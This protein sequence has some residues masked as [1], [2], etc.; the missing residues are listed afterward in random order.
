MKRLT[1]DG[2]RICK[3]VVVIFNNDGEAAFDQMVPSVG[4]IALR[5]LGAACNAVQ[6]LLTT[7]EKSS[8]RFE[9]HWEYR[10]NLILTYKTGFL[11]NYR[12][13]V[14]LQLC[15]WRSHVFFLVRCRNGQGG[16]RFAIQERISKFLE[17][18]RPST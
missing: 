6:T 12:V 1:Y 18:Q 2:M 7:F 11:E 5:R 3:L 9:I 10:R 13:R 17:W 8:T 15:G 14:H 16:L 4:G